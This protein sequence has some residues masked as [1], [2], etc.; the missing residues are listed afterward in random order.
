MVAQAKRSDPD[1]AADAM[2]EMLRRTWPQRISI[3]LGAILTVLFFLISGVLYIGSG[4]LGNLDSVAVNGLE[5]SAEGVENWLLVGTDSRAGIDPNDPNAD[6]ILD[7]KQPKRQSLT[8]TMMVAQVDS[9]NKTVRLLSIPRDLWVELP[10]GSEG[11]I[12]AAYSTGEGSDPARVV[13]TVEGSLEIKINQYA[14]INLAGFQEVVDALDGVPMWFD[15]PV[16]DKDSGLLIEEAGCTT[17]NGSEALAYSRSRK[18]EFFEDGRWKT[19][20]G[21]DFGRNDRQRYFLTRTADA[22][23]GKASISEAA[24]LNAVLAAAGENLTIA[25]TVSSRDLIGLARTFRSVGSAG[26]ESISLPVVDVVE[27]DAK[28]L[29][30]NDEEADEVLAPF[31]KLA[32]PL[33]EGTTKKSSFA[34]DVLN[35]SEVK[36]R[37][38]GAQTK[39][40]A[41]DFSVDSI[42][43]A[44]AA[45]TSTTVLYAPGQEAAAKTVA[46]YIGNDVVY[47]LDESAKNVTLV[48]GSDFEGI[49]S[50]PQGVSDPPQGSEPEEN[51]AP[52]QEPESPTI[53]IAPEGPP[54]GSE[55]A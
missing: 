35:A 6:V 12:N 55:C 54:P 15:T 41:A 16:R 1:L 25:N 5:P 11:R 49:L 44:D 48:L 31:R 3:A 18:I 4:L 19:G 2:P 40:E 13:K 30:L 43:N 22:V 14:E 42:G 7:K 46:S 21:N 52:T 45:T 27:G 38:A 37:A 36:G 29:A 28:V 24:E 39:L 33:P 20:G 50:E 51:V 17:L 10:D 26:I 8:D 23:A 53:G 34:V 32:E 9:G 47:E